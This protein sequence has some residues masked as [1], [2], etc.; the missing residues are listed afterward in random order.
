MLTFTI[1]KES[2]E[3]ERLW[4]MFS[5][6]KNL[7]DL[8][9]TRVCFYDPTV[10]QLHFIVGF[11]QDL[12]IGVLPLW[13]NKHQSYYEW[14]GGE[15]AEGNVFFL[16]D[17]KYL[18]DFF[19][20]LPSDTW[21]PYTD[22]R[23]DQYMKL[24]PHSVHETSYYVDLK[25]YGHNL[26]N[27]FSTFKGKHKKNLLRDLRLITEKNP[28]LHIVRND[29]NDFDRMMELNNKRFNENSF[30]AE[31]DFVTGLK[32]LLK[33]TNNKGELEMLSIHI[34]GKPESIEVA[35][36][37]NGVYTVI[38]GGNNLEFAN[39]GKVMT[40]EHL[41]NAIAKGATIVDFLA[42]DCGWK[43]LWNMDEIEW[44]NFSTT[45]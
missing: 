11:E 29:M 16:K 34:N 38:L 18:P 4:N 36:L 22:R 43:K 45:P 26:D 41:K 10:H 6:N 40:V 7:F 17:E 35:I 19:K 2:N 13:K 20:Q 44:C 8:W 33:S 3:C 14:F 15:F 24:L 12:L 21:L 42:Y 9:E 25:K 27:Y 5:P 39:I 28:D 1:V 37:K 31:P 30:F 32:K 23:Y